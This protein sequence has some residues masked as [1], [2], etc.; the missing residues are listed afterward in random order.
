MSEYGD[1]VQA[2]C[3]AFADRVVKLNDYLL[4][5]AANKK[6]G[7]KM[8]NGRYYWLWYLCNH[9][10]TPVLIQERLLRTR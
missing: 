4:S 7:F 5:Q 9:R 2:K 10:I 8:V 1:K 6:P 3:D